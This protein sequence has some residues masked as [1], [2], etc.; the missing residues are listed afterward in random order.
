M[1]ADPDMSAEAAQAF[2]RIRQQFVNGLPRRL[3]EI[4]QANDAEQRYAVLHRLAGVAGGYGYDH[5]GLLARQAMTADSVHQVELL[6]ELR[7]LI[8]TL[9][10]PAADVTI[11]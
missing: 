3:S 8:Q 7:Q 1:A 4:E 11:S 10:P 2:E 5:L 9:L 6:Q